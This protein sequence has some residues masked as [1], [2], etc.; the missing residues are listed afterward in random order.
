MLPMLAQVKLAVLLGMPLLSQAAPFLGGLFGNGNGGAAASA[1]V[2][3]TATVTVTLPAVTLFGQCQT[4]SVAAA[5]S[6]VSS[7][8]IPS[9]SAPA[10]GPASSS[11]VVPSVALS[12]AL[13]VPTT[14]SGG[15]TA[16]VN[17]L[18]NQLNV[19]NGLIANVAGTTP[20]LL[21]NVNQVLSS[22]TPALG[23]LGQ[24][25]QIVN[26]ATTAVGQLT[27]NLN[28]LTTQINQITSQ[29][30]AVNSLLNTLPSNLNPST[31]ANFPSA[32]AITLGQITS[33]ANSVAPVISQIQSASSNS[34]L[35]GI[36]LSDLESA[37][38]KLSNTCIIVI[39]N[40]RNTCPTAAGQQTV[41]NSGASAQNALATLL[42]QWQ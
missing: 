14:V 6:I 10:P 5:S 29:L 42:A 1:A 31:L 36:D 13:T 9:S 3:A 39:P 15:G 7:S 23:A 21:G 22:V 25:G 2:T 18:F 27:N 12:S 30:Q 4:T 37:W 17:N 35:G 8:A 16:G 40:F 26:G 20:S 34:A 32:A 38:Q 33:L 28:G 41:A 11:A 24:I 19:L